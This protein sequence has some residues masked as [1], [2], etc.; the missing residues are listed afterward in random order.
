MLIFCGAYPA[1][2]GHKASAAQTQSQAPV[3]PLFV[4][5]PERYSDAC[6]KSPDHDKA[7]LC[8]QWRAAI[9]AEKAAKEAARATNWA[10]IAT[11][12]SAAG[13]G[14]LIYTLFQTNGALT[15]ARRGNRIT[16]KANAR[17]TRQAVAGAADTATALA[18]AKQNA[19]AASEQVSISRDVEKKE[20]ALTSRFE[21]VHFNIILGP[22]R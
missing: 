6:Y 2:Q 15:E 7:D 18:F 13:V 20:C 1:L 22:V 12:L 8:A 11:L 4:A 3:D 9:A 21:P 14:G 5:Y 10:I 16:M 19:D 17:A